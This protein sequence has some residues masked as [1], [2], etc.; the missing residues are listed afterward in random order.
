VIRNVCEKPI[1]AAA[2]GRGIFDCFWTQTDLEEARIFAERI[3][4]CIEDCLV[5]DL[6]PDRQLKGTVSIGL[7]EHL[8]NEGIDRTIFRAD[9]AMYKAKKNGRNRV[10]YSE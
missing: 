2:T 3:R 7:A 6:E 4:A 8:K 10:E 9:E 1:S 5:F